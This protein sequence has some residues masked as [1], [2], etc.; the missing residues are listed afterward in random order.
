MPVQGEK[1]L[2]MMT[3]VMVV[4]VVMMM[5]TLVGLV[6]TCSMGDNWQIRAAVASNWFALEKKRKKG[7]TEHNHTTG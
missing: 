2:M 5:M 7:R 6:Q 1:Q 3:I 4:M